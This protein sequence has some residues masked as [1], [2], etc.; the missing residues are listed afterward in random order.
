MKT[1]YISDLH[2]PFHH[3]DALDFIAQ[4]H[5]T[6]KPDS[7]V[8]L[9]DEIDAHNFA[10]WTRHPDAI[11]PVEELRAAREFLHQ[12]SKITP[13]LLIVESNHTY[14]PWRRAAALGF[15]KEFLKSRAEVLETPKTWRWVESTHID[16]VFAIHG[17][18]YSGPDAAI[19]AARHYRSS[20]VI[21][22]VH[23]HAGIR[24]DVGETVMWGMNAGCLIDTSAPAF[25]YAR[26]H[27]FRPV[28][29]ASAVIDGVPMFFPLET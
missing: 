5:S 29:G 13:R 24:Y 4:L 17:E 19:N 26:H 9:G 21:G 16:G 28:L 22:H 2:S 11:G 6:L 10:R 23:S 7:C 15:G 20:T 25:D 3:T 14:R 8:C 27:R 12:L 1:L 18:G